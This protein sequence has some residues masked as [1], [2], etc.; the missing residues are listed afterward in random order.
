MDYHFRNLVFE[1]GGVKGIAY[2][3]AMDEL[4]KRGILKHI[5][6]VGGTS[7]GAINA[8][9]FA[10]GLS[11][12]ET[13]EALMRLEF[14]KFKDDDNG[15]LRDALRLLRKFGWYKGDFFENWIAG[16]IADKLGDATATFADLQKSRHIELYVYSTNLST[17]FGE[18]Y[19]PEDTPDE[20]IAKAVR[21]SMSIPLFFQAVRDARDDVLV[22]GGVLNNYPVKLFDREHYIDG[23]KVD[24]FCERPKYYSAVNENEAD[25]YVYNK[26]TLGLRLDSREE[27]RV[28]R[29]HRRP[30]HK[31]ISGFR[32]YLGALVKTIMDAQGNQHLH[33]DD[34]HRTIYIDTLGIGT[35]EFDLE[36]ADKEALIES[37]HKGANIYFDWYDRESK[38]GV[39]P[40][41]NMPRNERPSSPASN[42]GTVN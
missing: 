2:V 24:D 20:P 6:R 3:G 15:I 29:D 27:I 9:L 17:N 16:Y 37:G 4:D 11:N 35:T 32:D 26:E 34:W 28:F 10:L 38:K 21:K 7:A 22:D 18:I 31:T 13:K 8:T 25:K 19:S 30:C 39:N 41:K 5:K 40:P 12:E 14:R 33:T 36:I 23:A 42:A 1:G